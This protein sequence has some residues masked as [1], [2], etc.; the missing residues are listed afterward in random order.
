MLK[1]WRMIH[2]TFP[3]ESVDMYISNLRAND[4]NV[5]DSNKIKAIYEKSLIT[6][7]EKLNQKDPKCTDLRTKILNDNHAG[8]GPH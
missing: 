8:G 5:L 6:T 2:P 3:N 4:K 1:A 7:K